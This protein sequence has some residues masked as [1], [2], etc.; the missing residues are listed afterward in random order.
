MKF[1]IK[2]NDEIMTFESDKETITI[3]RSRDNDFVMPY[4]D[5]SRKHCQI[6]LKGEY[7]FIMD[8]GSKN[9]VS[10][11][12]RKIPPNEPMPIYT[13]SRVVL[14]NLFEFTLPDGTFIREDVIGDIILEE[15][16]KRG[17]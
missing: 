14:A 2:Y 13:T 12:G 10:I 17:R 8:L 7:A 1:R 9:G 5:F 3:G 16:I 15:P 4:D 11:D 6:T